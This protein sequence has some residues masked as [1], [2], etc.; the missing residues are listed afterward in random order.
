[1]NSQSTEHPKPRVLIVF[2]SWHG[3][4]REVA[5]K[6]GEVALANGADAEI[7][8]A[9]ETRGDEKSITTYDG[10]VVVGSV[11]FAV[12]SRPLRR[13]VRRGLQ[14]LS[15][16]RSAFV[17][18]SGAAAALDGQKQAERY[19]QRFLHATGWKPDMVFSC[20]GA[21]RFTAYDPIT[22]AA[23]K[24]ASRIAGRGTDVS[25]D[26]VYTNWPAVHAFTHDFLDMLERSKAIAGSTVAL[27]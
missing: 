13:F 7:R 23:M 3:H 22:R 20:A 1:M 18:I 6:M 14:H 12:H 24:F 8:D 27:A 16:V 2:A 21:V 15:R 4:A 11:H 10:V 9:S 26:Y 25:R 5:E 17:S 19:I